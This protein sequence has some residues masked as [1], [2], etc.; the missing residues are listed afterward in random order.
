MF[1][2][3]IM[4]PRVAPDV[5]R[6]TLRAALSVMDDAPLVI[7]GSASDELAGP[8]EVVLERPLTARTSERFPDGERHVEIRD[9]VRGRAVFVVQSTGEPVGES[10]IE[11]LLLADACRRGGARRLVAVLPYVGYARQDRRGKESEALGIGVFAAALATGRFDRLVTVDLHAPGTEA[12][13]ASPVDQ[14]SAIPLLAEE[15]ADELPARPVVVAPDHGAARMARAVAQRIS[16]PV[17]V[18]HKQRRSGSEVAVDHVVGDVVD[19]TP[20]IVDDILATGGTIAAAVTAVRERGATGP[21]IVVVSHLIPHAGAAARL[22]R[23]S[24]GR[25]ITTDSLRLGEPWPLRVHRV[26]LAPLLADVIGRI[27]HG[28]AIDDLAV[29][30]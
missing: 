1:T 2:S 22:S 13:F 24:I 11:L 7:I 5:P 10:L 15:L 9:A 25:L 4:V 18:V 8:L 16:A 29:A 17:A 12:A 26:G 6:G 28:G 3:F 30:R 23:A 20:I 27:H 21:A 19:R 14:I